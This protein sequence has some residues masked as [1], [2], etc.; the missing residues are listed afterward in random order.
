MQR[1]VVRNFGPISY[2]EI[3]IRKLVVLIGDNAIGKST[4]IKLISTFLWIE[5]SLFRGTV[6]KWFERDNR[7]KNS[8][9]AYHRIDNFLS[10]NSEIEYYGKAYIIR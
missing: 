6:K 5:K 9:L 8:L 1:L 10:Q 3:P 2:A 7:L 4:V